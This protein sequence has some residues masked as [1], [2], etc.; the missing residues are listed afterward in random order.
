[1]GYYR[2]VHEAHHLGGRPSSAALSLV[3]IRG[4]MTVVGATTPCRTEPFR[5]DRSRTLSSLSLDS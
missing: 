4:S 3:G 1:M 2:I 5:A